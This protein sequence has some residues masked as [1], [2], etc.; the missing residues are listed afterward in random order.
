MSG[1]DVEGQVPAAAAVEEREI[2]PYAEAAPG[3][4][5][6]LAALL[7]ELDIR[8]SESVLSFGVEA[9]KTL[10]Q[11]SDQMLE[12]VRAKDAGAAGDALNDMVTAL[13]GFDLVELN[14]NKPQ[15]LLVRWFSSTKPI[16]RFVQ[17]YE[18]VKEQIDR[19]G[20]DL[21]GHKSR[22]L[23]DVTKL[24]ALYGSTLEYFESLERYIAAGEERLRRLDADDLPAL[25]EKADD[26]VIA[27][28]KLADLRTARD[29]LERRVHDLRLTRQVAM[30]A[31]PGIRMIQGN[32]K[33]LVEKIQSTLINTLPLWRQ[34]LAQALTLYNSGQAAEALRG[35]TDLTN[36]LLKANA[37][38][39]KE[40][41]AA[42]RTQIERGVFDIESVREAN[43]TLISA[44][45][46]GLKIA[47]E[48]KKA[49]AAADEELKRMEADLHRALSEAAR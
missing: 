21:E 27:A 15:S 12:G 35:A 9:Q 1:S 31:L 36:D 7:H 24:D 5:V 17:E 39:L 22:L 30:Q 46:D 8:N 20:R 14:P 41:N 44:I 16:V 43:S 34:Q 38:S 48:G 29:G 28:Q 33:G 18:G 47:E 37:E 10:T 6:Q 49:R 40:I 3:E 25:A 45:E 23:E 13:R 32:D 2:V 11:I 26:D 19:V 4:R 42:A